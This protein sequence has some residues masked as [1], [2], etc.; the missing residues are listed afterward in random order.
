MIPSSA[1]K[2]YLDSMWGSTTIAK[3]MFHMFWLIH[4]LK[5]K[6]LMNTHSYELD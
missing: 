2:K 5:Y 1:I 3:Y 6:N 4:T